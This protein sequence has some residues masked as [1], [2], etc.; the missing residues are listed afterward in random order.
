MYSYD[1]VCWFCD[2]III[3]RVENKLQEHIPPEVSRLSEVIIFMDCGIYS[4]F[5]RISDTIV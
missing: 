5:K 4:C 3:G 2:S 1:V